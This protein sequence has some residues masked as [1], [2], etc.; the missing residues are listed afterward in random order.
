MVGHVLT[1]G[2]PDALLK[3][4][5]TGAHPTAAR[6]WRLDERP[7]AIVRFWFKVKPDPWVTEETARCCR[8]RTLI[9]DN[10][11]SG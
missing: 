7:V 4:R 8:R 1:H 10:P 9:E 2:R 6:Q 3:A 11:A 5:D